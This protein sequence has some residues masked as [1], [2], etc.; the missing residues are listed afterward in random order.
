MKII[1]GDT[2]ILHCSAT[3]ADPKIDVDTI[4]RWHV[5]GRGW[6]DIGYHFVILTDGRIQRGRPLN[7][8]GAHTKG[9]NQNIGVCYVGGVSTD[10]KPKDTMTA[11]QVDSFERL[12][13]WLRLITGKRYH[14]KGHN[15]YTNLKACPSFKVDVKFKHLL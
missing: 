14:I 13:K 9:Y 15:D 7:R 2:I 4:R 10:G 5:K 11:L 3:T 6:S 1:T 12:V 8:N